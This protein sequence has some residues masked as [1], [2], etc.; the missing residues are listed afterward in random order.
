MD[1]LLAL[2]L[3]SP[4]NA[5]GTALRVYV[6]LRQRGLLTHEWRPMKLDVVS[7]HVGIPRSSASQ[8]M[9]WLVQHGHL[10]AIADGRSKEYRIPPKQTRP[11]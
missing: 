10:E 5:K 8:V 2:A 7:Y 3:G 11:V 1:Q 6:I 4:K 9:R